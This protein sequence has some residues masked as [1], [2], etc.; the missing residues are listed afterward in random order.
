MLD[1]RGENCSRLWLHP[2]T[3]TNQSKIPPLS[4]LI[5]PHWCTDSSVWL[6]AGSVALWWGA[7]NRQTAAQFLKCPPPPSDFLWESHSST[8]CFTCVWNLLFFF[9]L[10]SRFL[11]SPSCFSISFLISLSLF[12]PRVCCPG[13]L[14]AETNSCVW[15]NLARGRCQSGGRPQRL[16]VFGNKVNTN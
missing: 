8:F 2:M 14:T 16:I 12:C 9:L 10:P 13:P 3:L 1:W 6:S 4:V 15:N 5:T 7:Q 11:F